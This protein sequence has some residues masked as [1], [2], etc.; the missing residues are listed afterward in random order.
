MKEQ[1]RLIGCT[2]QICGRKYK[3]DILVPDE[4][5]N[6][7]KLELSSDDGSGLLCGSCIMTKIENLNNFRSFEML[8]L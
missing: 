2:C 8:P 7:I 4:I 1:E 6:I 3:V 5:W